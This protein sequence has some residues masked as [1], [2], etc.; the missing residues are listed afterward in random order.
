MIKQDRTTARTGLEIAVIGMAARFPGARN[1]YEFWSNLRNG[2][3]SIS[4]FSDQELEAGGIDKRLLKNPDYVKG[5]ACLDDKELFDTSFFGYTPKEAEL[6][7]PQIRIFHECVWEALEDAGYNPESYDEKIGIYAGATSS[8]Y[9]EALSHLTGKIEIFG[10]FASTHLMDR[11]YLCSRVSYNLNLKGASSFVQST[12]S[13]SLVSIHH[14]S[15]ALLTGESEMVLAGGISTSPE[16]RQ[17]YLYQEGMIK[18]SDGHC[19]AF[20]ANASGTV[21]GEGV[22]VVALKRLKP[23]LEDNDHIYAIIRGTAINNDGGRKVGFTAPSIEAQAE[24]IRTA[25]RMARIEAESITYIETHG[26]GTALGDPVEIEALKLAFNTKKRNYCGIGAVK[27]NIGHLDTAAGAAGF[28]KTV[29]TLTHRQIP[30]SLHFNNPNPEID[31]DNSPFYVV[32]GLKNWENNVYPLRAGVSSFGIGGTNAHVI[33]EEWPQEREQRTGD[34]RE[35]QLILLSTK[36]PS[37]LDK[38][39]QN[40]AD[41]FKE[42]PGINLANAA[43]TLHIG[44][45]AF[46]HRRMLV[47]ENTPGAVDILSTP[48]SAELR[49]FL[50]KTDIPSIVFMFPGQGAQ[51][52]NMGLDL[53]R[54]EPIFREEIDRCFEILK[55]TRGYNLKEILYPGDLV[56][57]VSKVSEENS[58]IFYSSNKSNQSYMSNINQTE[59]TQ[60][61]LFAFEYALAKLLMKWGIQPRAMVGHSIGEYVAACLAGVFSLEDALNLVAFRG[62]KMQQ[63]PPGAML[64][65]NMSQE[66]L[67][68]LL[69]EDISIAAVNS[70]SHCVVSGTH[71]A[72]EAF[73][74]MLERNDCKFKRLHTSH[75]FHSK[76]MDL[77]IGTFTEK[78]RQVRLNKPGIPY[79]S[80]VTGTWIRVEEA[81]DPVYWARHLRETV[82]FADSI[83]LLVKLETPI[84]VEVGPGKVLSTFVKY[85]Q[86]KTQDKEQGQEPGKKQNRFIITLIKHPKEK[87][88]DNR[89]LL[90]KIG[91]LWLYG[92]SLDWARFHEGQERRRLPLPLYP[93]EGKRFLLY[94][95]PLTISPGILEQSQ[96]RKKKDMVDWFYIPSWERSMLPAVDHPVINNDT[97]GQSCWLVFLNDCELSAKLVK[98][99]KPYAQDVITVKTGDTF[100]QTGTKEFRLNPAVAKDYDSLFFEL[101][102]AENIPDKIIHLWNVNGNT[103][104]IGLNGLD[105][106]QDLGLYSLLNIVQALGRQNIASELQMQVVTNNMQEVTGGE[107]ECPDKATML[108]AVKIIPLE[109]PNISCR[110]IDIVLPEPSSTRESKLA[111]LLVAEFTTDPV[112]NVIALR[113]DYRWI[114]TIKPVPLDM[115]QEIPGILKEKGV[116]LI[117]GGFGGMGFTLAEFLAKHLKARLILVGRSEFPGKEKWNQWLAQDHAGADD[118]KKQKIWKL[119]EWEKQGAEIMTASA[120]ITDYQQMKEIIHQV[121]H[122]FGHINGVIHAAGIVDYGGFIQRRTREYT[123]IHMASKVRGTLVLDHLLQDTPLD[124]CA[125][126]SSIGNILYSGKFGEV[127]YNAANE[128]LDAFSYYKN[129]GNGTFFV[130]INWTDWQEVGMSVDV[131]KRQSPGSTHFDYESASLDSVTPTEGTEVFN[132]ILQSGLPRAVVS[133]KDLNLLAAQQAV[134]LKNR[135]ADL[136]QNP[137]E[138]HPSSS[139]SQRPELT[140]RYVAPR[141]TM[142][143]L[144]GKV[145]QD[146]L[147]IEEIGINDNFFDL[148]ATS[149]TMVQ[150]NKNLNQALKKDIPL[151]TMFNYSTVRSLAEYLIPQESQK[152]GTGK[153]DRR[154]E[155]KRGRQSLQGRY[156]RHQKIKERQVND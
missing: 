21:V 72:M 137:A 1:I 67:M 54:T 45:K 28:I 76:M 94:D 15:R 80:N 3:E 145:F 32:P 42:H 11:D 20:D 89:Y 139:L 124:F 140:T 122:R 25:Q 2:V 34:T 134:R 90:G 41:Y 101:R 69:G 66:E 48:D 109:Y 141:N 30:P 65:I 52:I 14:A 75:A 118:E 142:E 5:Y 88:A 111:S 29:L 49:T 138:S 61:V 24:V 105:R 154:Q 60:P 85:F 71:E 128:F 146:F 93:F 68:P 40:L 129:R 91:E 39:T 8:F 147:G 130:T 110:S 113:G 108:G 87:I 149:L 16:P 135:G 36:T 144:I 27:S 112:D 43:Y 4:F 53:Y 115:Q 38:M 84:F 127:S 120:D 62:E 37:A 123:E 156:K 132:R 31:F 86:D 74:G 78:V 73:A 79:I 22:G 58:C 12:C 6:M 59:V 143:Q 55:S 152:S 63:M 82:R 97:A 10:A 119:L 18:S 102:R 100:A 99:I 114:Q 95:D 57:E 46:K 136:L 155:M 117:V 126:F 131:L 19:R 133:T 153:K 83:D 125:L 35:Y 77:I 51:Y 47:C 104:P 106:S 148:G 50:A 17:G 44:R 7:N 116:Y 70:S 103:L 64:S 96:L 56:R 33:L 9:W 26:T 107:L 92:K 121:K 13:T 23:A 98:Q 81:T 151:V 150:I